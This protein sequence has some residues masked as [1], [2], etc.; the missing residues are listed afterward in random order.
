M[1]HVL[2]VPVVLQSGAADCGYACLTSCVRHF[3]DADFTFDV[4]ARACDVAEW[5]VHL[6]L[7]LA[8]RTELLVEMFTTFVGANPAHRHNTFYVDSAAAADDWADEVARV[9]S[10]FAMA[11][12][13]GISITERRLTRD[14]LIRVVCSGRACIC[15]VDNRYIDCAHCTAVTPLDTFARASYPHYV[16]HFVVVH[17]VVDATHFA[18]MNPSRTCRAPFCTVSMN[19]FERARSVGGTDD[20]VIIVSAASGRP[21]PRS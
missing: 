12:A 19:D 1:Q 21:R 6:L 7:V 9:D 8:E 3:A 16:G 17:G 14:D 10:A 5:T 18:I 4:G 15:A 11:R 13:R 2:G 20:D